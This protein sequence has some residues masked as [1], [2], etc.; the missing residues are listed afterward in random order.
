MS[1]RVKAAQPSTNVTSPCYDGITDSPQPGTSIQAIFT[2]ATASN[3]AGVSYIGFSSDDTSLTPM[4][5]T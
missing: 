3:S 4:E 2:K 1:D 5:V